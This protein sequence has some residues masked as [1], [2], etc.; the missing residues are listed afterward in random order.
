M[1]FHL[2]IFWTLLSLAMRSTWPNQFNLWF[3]INPII[4]HPFSISLISWLVLI[5]QYPSSDLVGPNIL[6][7]AL[8][9]KNHQF[10]YHIFL[11]FPCFRGISYCWVN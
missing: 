8:S 5:L 6:A 1:G 3:L 9:F 4:F 11:K 7:H 2:L 10:V